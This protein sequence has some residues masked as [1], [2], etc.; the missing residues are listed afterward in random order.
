MDTITHGIA[1]AL[2]GK[3]IFRG[4]D[5]LASPPMNRGRIITWSLMLGAIFPDSDVVRDIFSHDKLLVITWHRSITHSLV[6]LP[7]WALLLAGITRVFANSRKWEAPSFVALAGIYAVGILSHIVLD[8]VTSFGTMIWSPLAWSRP[9]WDLIFIIDFTLT[10]LLL[11]P[12]VLAWVYAHPQKWKRRAMG[13]WLVFLPAPFLIAR[14]GEVVGAPIS[15]RVVLLAMVI[16][17]A[18]FFLPELL[19]GGG[20]IQHDTWNRA[21]LA[22]A[23]IYVACTWYTHHMALSRIQKFAELGRL[24]VDSIGALPLPPSL[25][26]WDGLVRSEHGVY[27]LRMD[28]SQQAVSNEELLA[29]EHHYYPDAPPNSFIE[30]AKRLPEVQK[31][32]WFSR[33]PVTRFHQEGDVAVVEISDLRFPRVRPGRPASFTYRVRLGTDGNVLSQGWATR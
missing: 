4:Q 14:M 9:A 21:G 33:F 7:L 8:L 22:A 2:I 12:Q 6:M 20:K 29:L 30:V 5:L 23:V 32:L 27:E 31:V 24:Q 13:M 10:A 25:W 3:A 28:L 16:S 11:V 19:G 15:D 26:H 18:L 1:G 17:A